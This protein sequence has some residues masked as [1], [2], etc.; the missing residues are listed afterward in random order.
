MGSTS[1]EGKSEVEDDV[2]FLVVDVFY[3]IFFKSIVQYVNSLITQGAIGNLY[4]EFFA[5]THRIVGKIT[6]RIVWR[7][8][9]RQN[10]IAF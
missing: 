7:N 10:S 8:V 6:E 4:W 5:K 3:N 1:H 2:T 9:F